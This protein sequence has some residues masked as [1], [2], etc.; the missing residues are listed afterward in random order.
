MGTRGKSGCTSAHVDN[1]GLEGKEPNDYLTQRAVNLRVYPGTRLKTC[2]VTR[3]SNQE[4]S[5]RS[6][7]SAVHRRP[8]SNHHRRR[9]AR[10]GAPYYNTYS[11]ISDVD[12]M[13]ISAL[14][15][16]G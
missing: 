11:L 3:A 10:P 2:T 14:R 1:T 8:L 12:D 13:T 7:F 16:R 15:I 5:Q 6:E 9:S 4:P